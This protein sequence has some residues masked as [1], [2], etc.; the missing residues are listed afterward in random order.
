MESETRESGNVT[1]KLGIGRL[2]S[3]GFWMGDYRE[4]VRVRPLGAS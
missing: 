3:E 2:D 4:G 1:V